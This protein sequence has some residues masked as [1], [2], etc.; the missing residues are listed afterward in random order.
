LAAAAPQHPPAQFQ[1]SHH[2]PGLGFTNAANA[3]ELHFTGAGQLV[4][5]ASGF[6]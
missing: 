1:E 5:R 6:Q 2:P 4:Q 3:H